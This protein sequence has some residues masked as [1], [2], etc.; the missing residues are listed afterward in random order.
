MIL[1]IWRY[2]WKRI[3]GIWKSVKKTSRACLVRCSWSSGWGGRTNDAFTPTGIC[4]PIHSTTGSHVSQH[5][6]QATRRWGSSLPRTGSMEFSHLKQDPDFWHLF[7]WWLLWV[8]KLNPGPWHMTV[9]SLCCICGPASILLLLL[10][11]FSRARNWAHHEFWFLL[12]FY[13]QR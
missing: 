13:L 3:Q 1:F 8:W 5:G 12:E 7:A 2:F 11:L 6:R 4:Y 10:P 9:L